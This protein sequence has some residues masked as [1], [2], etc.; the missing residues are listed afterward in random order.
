M[1]TFIA[2]FVPL[3]V[4]T[5]TRCRLGLNLPAGNAGDLG[6]DAAQVLLLTADGDLVAQ[7]GGLAANFALLGHDYWSG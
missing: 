1:H 7:L 2:L 5:C 3:D 4:V 6:A